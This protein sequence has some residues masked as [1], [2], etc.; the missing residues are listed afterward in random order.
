MTKYR[1]RDFYLPG[2]FGVYRAMYTI[3][4]LFKGFLPVLWDHFLEENIYPSLLVPG[5]LIALYINYL[6]MKSCLRI[7]DILFNEG[8]KI[9]FRVFITLFKF[10]KNVLMQMRGDK[11]LEYV[12]SIPYELDSDELIEKTLSLTLSRKRVY[13][14]SL[15]FQEKPNSEYIDW[16]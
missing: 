9:L 16:A 1:M 12:K 6:P 15:E 13:A 4:A 7:F 2:M 8:V 3:N 10:K 14:L 5:W 11:I